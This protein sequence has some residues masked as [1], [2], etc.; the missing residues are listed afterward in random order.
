LKGAHVRQE[1]N[2]QDNL[3]VIESNGEVLRKIYRH[4]LLGGVWEKVTLLNPEWQ[5][6]LEIQTV[7]LQ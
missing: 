4:K 1:G 2:D 5:Y 6:A 7:R 3:R